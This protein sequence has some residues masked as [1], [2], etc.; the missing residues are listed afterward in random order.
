MSDENENKPAASKRNRDG[1]EPRVAATIEEATELGFY[2]TEVDPVPNEHY[3]L[4][5]VTSGKPTPETDAEVAEA[6]RR[7][8]KAHGLA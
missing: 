3:T 7:H 8:Q 6:V 4:A 2:G 5:G 1:G